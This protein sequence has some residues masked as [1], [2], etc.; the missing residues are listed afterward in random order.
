MY[1]N[2]LAP[3]TGQIS[4]DT[5]CLRTLELRGVG[6]GEKGHLE[7]LSLFAVVLS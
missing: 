5:I 4:F 2:T 3:H 1:T 7:V 6:G